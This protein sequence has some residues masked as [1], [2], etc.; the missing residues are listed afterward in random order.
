MGV[1]VWTLIIGT[2]WLKSDGD[3]GQADE[4]TDANLHQLI[5]KG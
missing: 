1:I 5:M 3:L 4:Q 2:W